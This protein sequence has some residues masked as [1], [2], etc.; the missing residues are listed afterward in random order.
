M[1]LVQSQNSNDSLAGLYYLT[2]VHEMASAFELKP[3]KT[4]KFFF[5]YGALDRYASGTW[6]AENGNI[7]FNTN[8]KPK[9]DFALISSK[10]MP[11]T[12]TTIKITEKNEALLRYVHCFLKKGKEEIHEV[13]NQKGIATIPLANADSLTLIF[14][15][16]Q[17]RSSSF[18][19]TNKQDN[20]FEFRFE[21][22]AFEVFL[23]DFKLK[24]GYEELTG[25]HPLLEK[26]EYQY[27]KE[28]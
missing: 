10:T 28:H 14:E 3:D 13:T 25:G 20:Y 11:G 4:F 26:D 6:N 8:P 17:E 1:N 12:A 21:P 2:G 16:A 15:F 23:K 22:W 18:P 5:T 24:I 7:V 9:A 19:I 27:K